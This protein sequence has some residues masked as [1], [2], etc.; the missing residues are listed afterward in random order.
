[1]KRARP[2]KTPPK[3][4]GATTEDKAMTPPT[5]LAQPRTRRRAAA[6]SR[7]PSRAARHAVT[8]TPSADDPTLALDA[9]DE[10]L[11]EEAPELGLGAR[12]VPPHVGWSDPLDSMPPASS[13][14]GDVAEQ[15]RALEARLDGL[16]RT[17]AAK[18]ADEPAPESDTTERHARQPEPPE[19]DGD[20]IAK[21]QYFEQQWGREGMRSRSEEVDDFGLDPG[22]ESRFRPLA[23]FLY[24]RYFRVRTLGINN[25]PQ[26]GR[27]I[28]VANHS[29]TL[30]LDGLMLRTALR[31][32]QPGARELRWLAEDFLFYLPFAGVF[33]NRVGAVRACQ[34]NAER[35]LAKENLLAVFPEG[36][37]GIRKLFSERYR[38]QRFGRGGYIRLALRMQAPIVPC[39]IVG[40]EET[41]PLLYRLEYVAGLMGLPYIP[42]TPTFPLLGPLGLMPAPSRWTIT[43]GE[44]VS[45][46]GAGPEAAEDHVL[47]GR[48]SERVRSSIQAMLDTGVRE[49]KSVWFG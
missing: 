8:N 20:D 19:L 39:A 32:E 42:V 2:A 5:Q 15:I 21:S 1:M 45:L 3:P 28:V 22:Y 33:M 13:Q 7:A 12:M 29:G 30:P 26:R 48:L 27:C 35:L 49:R 11:I 23:D 36:V 44:P 14:H 37:Q 6:P 24:R 46:D 9:E 17:G 34:E 41:N 31:L 4:R 40:A 38:L 16:I 25:V 43:F 10:S 18:V 47:V